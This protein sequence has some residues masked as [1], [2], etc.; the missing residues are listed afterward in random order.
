MPSEWRSLLD[1][2]HKGDVK[3]LN[4]ALAA[5]VYVNMTGGVS[6]IL[7]KSNDYFSEDTFEW[8]ISVVNCKLS[9]TCCN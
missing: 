2:A 1:I 6:I 3:A 7:C 8:A 5:G 9:W 4:E